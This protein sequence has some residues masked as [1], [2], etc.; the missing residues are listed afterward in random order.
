MKKIS[1]ITRLIILCCLHQSLFSQNV[2]S[3]KPSPFSSDRF[4]TGGD[5]GLNFGSTTYIDLSPIL[6]YKVTDNFSVGPGII[7]VYYRDNIYNFTLNYYGAKFF[8]RYHITDNLFAHAEEQM[9]NVNVSDNNNNSLSVYVTSFLV[10]GGYS[11]PIG[12]NSFFTITGLWNLTPSV[13]SPYRN[14]I[15]RAGF[16]I[17]L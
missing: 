6:G 7:Y 17:G 9:L 13:Y 16:N 11:Q 3:A 10:G 8:A 14:P 5:I 12:G 1:F 4:Y 15:I 2:P